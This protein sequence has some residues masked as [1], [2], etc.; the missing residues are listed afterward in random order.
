MKCS[1]IVAFKFLEYYTFE[2]KYSM[3][4]GI[5]VFACLLSFSAY[6]QKNAEKLV[7]TAG[8]KFVFSSV[9][10]VKNKQS[11]GGETSEMNTLS[12]S[13]VE[14]TV[15]DQQKEYVVLTQ[16]ISKMKLDFEGFGTKMS[17]DSEN[18]DKQSGMMADQ[19]KALVNKVDTIKIDYDGNILE[20]PKEKKG[21]RGGRGG[22]GGMM[23]AMN[24][25]G[26]SF[27]RAFLFV[28]NGV[29]EGQGWKKDNTKDNLKSQTIYFVEK[30]K[31]DMVELSF[32]RKTKGTRTFTTP[33]GPNQI[34][35]DNLSEGTLTVNRIT[36]RVKTYTEK[37][38]TSS[39]MNMM[40][41]DMPSTGTT[42][43]S[44]TID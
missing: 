40:G 3:K 36:G 33:Q 21:E 39:K 1:T 7:V 30:I 31:G 19:M 22:G 12:Q 9:D 2:K 23:R 8:Q 16:K 13:N 28:P 20:E 32:K 38:Q 27:D 35:I 6:A 18:P 25:S 5:L 10:T 24:Q 34:D 29:T 41:V 37:I 42:V 26:A 14:F 11:R 15:I 44:L 43:S 17:Y 4:K